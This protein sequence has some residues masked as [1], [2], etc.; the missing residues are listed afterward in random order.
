M[1]QLHM[2]E[3]KFTSSGIVYVACEQASPFVQLIRTDYGRTLKDRAEWVLDYFSERGAD[4]LHEVITKKIG[5]WAIEFQSSAKPA[6][7]T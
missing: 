1:Q 2:I 3:T 5:R 6:S 7:T 4:H